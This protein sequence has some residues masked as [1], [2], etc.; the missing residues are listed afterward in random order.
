MAAEHP[1]SYQVDI[2]WIFKVHPNEAEDEEAA[3]KLAIARIMEHQHAL[4][5]PV[6]DFKTLKTEVG[7]G[8][9]WDV[10]VGFSMHVAALDAEDAINGAFGQ[11]EDAGEQLHGVLAHID[12]EEQVPEPLDRYSVLHTVSMP[13]YARNRNEAMQFAGNRMKYDEEGKLTFFAD[14]M[15]DDV[16]AFVSLRAE[17]QHDTPDAERAQPA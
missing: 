5:Y 11:I 4:A 13:V 10:T 9:F 1:Q 14:A 3:G 12:V 7:F 6:G 17:E 2:H 8:G 16:D 15:I